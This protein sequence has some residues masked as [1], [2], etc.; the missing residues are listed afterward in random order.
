MIKKLSILMPVFNEE[1]RIVKAVQRVL[2]VKLGGLSKEIIIINDGSTDGT[3]KKLEKIR[4]LKVVKKEI[5]KVIN[6][7]KNQGKGAAIRRGLKAITGD[8]VVIQDTDLEYDPEEYKLL[9]KPILEG[10]ADV[11]FGSRFMGDRP[12]RVLLFW[13]MVANN[14]LTLIS[15]MFTNINLTDMETGYKMFTSEVAHRLNIQ[16]NRFGME[17]EF[18]AKVAKMNCRIFEVGV[19]YHGRNYDQ[20]KKI[21]WKDGVWALWCVIRYNLFD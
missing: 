18:T 9:L 14:L 11:V 6:L 15:N 12:H 19:S 7:S 1:K 20:G 13:H 2:A 3:I 16:E 4:N 17:P 21:T 8:V 5:I 10:D